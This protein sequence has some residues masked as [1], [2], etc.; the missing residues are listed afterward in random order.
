M[1]DCFFHFL[2]C[3][4][5]N[6]PFF[7]HENSIKSYLKERY[8]RRCTAEVPGEW[9]GQW[10]AGTVPLS[11]PD[12]VEAP[13][14]SV[15]PRPPS[16]GCT[17]SHFCHFWLFCYLSPATSSLHQYFLCVKYEHLKHATNTFKY[18]WYFL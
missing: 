8:Q 5:Y 18:F 6:K 7:P 1:H 15:R 14:P 3:K 2:I 12:V 10:A 11:K 4:S 17:S 13:L 16:Q 9:G